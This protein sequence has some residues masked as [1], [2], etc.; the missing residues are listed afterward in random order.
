[1]EPAPVRYEVRNDPE[2]LTRV[3]APCDVVLRRQDRSEGASDQANTDDRD[4]ETLLDTA[5][6]LNHD[7]IF[8]LARLWSMARLRGISEQ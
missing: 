4:R 6:H 2:L 3:T 1:V 7:S 5:R 8:S